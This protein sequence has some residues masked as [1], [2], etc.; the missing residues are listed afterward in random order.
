MK[1]KDIIKDAPKD[2]DGTLITGFPRQRFSRW[3]CR[4][5]VFE[6][7]NG[8]VKEHFEDINGFSRNKKLENLR[9]VERKALNFFLSKSLLIITH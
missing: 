3:S 1:T 4:E 7:G 5:V 2:F 6:F 9:E 8:R